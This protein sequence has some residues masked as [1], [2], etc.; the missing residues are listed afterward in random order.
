MLFYFCERIYP[1]LKIMGVVLKRP[2]R[3]QSENTQEV[4]Q[5]PLP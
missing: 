2:R 1:P 5:Y 3:V 4:L